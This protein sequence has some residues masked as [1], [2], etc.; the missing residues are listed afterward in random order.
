MRWSPA[1]EQS[2]FTGWSTADAGLADSTLG[3]WWLDSKAYREGV[4]REEFGES[5]FIPRSTILDIEC[6]RRNRRKNREGHT[7]RL[8]AIASVRGR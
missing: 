3:P 7:S 8:G 2:S 4:E 5:A 6:D 1:D